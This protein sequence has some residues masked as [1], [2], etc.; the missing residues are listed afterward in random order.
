MDRSY[1]GCAIGQDNALVWDEHKRIVGRLDRSP[2][3]FPD[4]QNAIKPAIQLGGLKN[5]NTG[6]EKLFNTIAGVL[7]GCGEVGG[8]KIGRVQ[9]GLNQLHQRTPLVLAGAAGIGWQY[10]W[11]DRIDDEQCR[12]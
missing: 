8:E 7:R 2:T 12:A 6:S 11:R 10:E 9:L 3:H 5:Q 4:R 1:A